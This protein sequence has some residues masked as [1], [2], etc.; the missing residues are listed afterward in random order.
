MLS[1]A[2]VGAATSGKSLK[3]AMPHPAGWSPPAGHVGGVAAVLPARKL[4]DAAARVVRQRKSHEV[5]IT[6][7]S[8]WLDYFGTII[9]TCALDQVTIDDFSRGHVSYAAFT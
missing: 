7:R 9:N 5:L 6:W 1:L 8:D 4:T 2:V 3:P